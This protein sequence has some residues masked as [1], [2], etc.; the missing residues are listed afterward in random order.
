MSGFTDY[1]LVVGIAATP[2]IELRGSI[3]FAI[4]VLGMSIPVAVALSLLGNI[5]LFIVVYLVG[6]W[7]IKLMDS[8]R[9]FLS[10]L[11]NVVLHRSRRVLG[12]GQYEKF[13]LLAL[14]VFVAV[15]LPMTG[16]L[17]GSVAAFLFGVPWRRA[18]LYVFLGMCLAALVVTLITTGVLSFLDFL[19]KQPTI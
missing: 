18:C 17:T 3:P 5:L 9:S 1:L 10:R 7:W 13:G 15:P 14:T 19:L 11:T 2:I 8:H 16:V 12:N 6:G 4:G